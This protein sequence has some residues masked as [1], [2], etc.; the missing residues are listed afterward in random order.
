MIRLL[1]LIAIIFAFAFGFAWLADLP[2]D[3]T[4]IWLDEQI[5]VNPSV[6]VVAVLIA[7]VVLLIVVSVLRTIIKSPD[8][9]RRFFGRRRRDKGYEALS[10]ALIALGS[11]DSAAAKRYARDAGK[12]LRGAPVTQFLEAQVAQQEDR[13]DDARNIYQ[14]LTLD[15]RTKL[16][17]LH[18]L[19]LEA[20]QQGEAEVAKHYAEQAVEIAPHLPWAGQALFELQCAERDWEAALK[21]LERNQHSK[22]VDRKAGRRLRAVLLTA[23]AGE[24]EDSEPE[25]ARKLALEAHGLAPEL[26]PAS[27]IAGRVL[28]RLGDVRKAAKVLET[29]W[30]KETHPEIAESYAYVR[31]GDSVKDRLQR[32]EDLAKMRANHPEG[33]MALARV[34]IDAQEW[35]I[36]RDALKRVFRS[37]PTREACLLMSELEEAEHGD[38]GRVREWLARAVRAPR[39]PAWTA[40]GVVS[41]EWAPISPVTGRLDAFE[42][43]VPV[44]DLDEEPSPVIEDAMLDTLP[45]PPPAP[46]LSPIAEP[47]TVEAAEE[48]DVIDIE[49]SPVPADS[50]AETEPA[51]QK[52]KT[53]GT[54]SKQPGGEKDSADPVAVEPAQTVAAD[55]A[56]TTAGTDGAEPIETP[57]APAEAI[58]VDG[59][60]ADSDVKPNGH[61][62]PAEFPLRSRPDD[63]GP[64]PK[65]EP[66]EKK[67]FSLFS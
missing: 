30:K 13:A 16:L 63:P 23:R 47:E 41:E 1:I 20:R 38:R 5:D 34:A 37:G 27:V 6:A 19:F 48:V 43:K 49:E 7:V 15:D 61:D 12:Q 66:E 26:V 54:E 2:G 39:D 22:L 32:I 28:A 45:P 25:Q 60:E 29:T 11:G 36:A 3:I 65:A 8:S 14:T 50:K 4:I 51:E 42:W 33:S 9:L 58:P 24:L 21:T 53:G 52:S 55:A 62:L 40:D 31:P 46:P 18:G 57:P 56:E 59:T 44:E 10:S 35:E 17:G 64:K 67:R